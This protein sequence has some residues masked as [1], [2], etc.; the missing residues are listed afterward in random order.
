M[1]SSVIVLEPAE[2]FDLLTLQEAK[3]NLGLAS[4]DTSLDE[5]LEFLI[6]RAS[7]EMATLCDRVFA[8]ER[9]L[10]IFYD[11]GTAQRLYLS[12]YPVKPSDIE[13]ISENGTLL[14]T[15]DV[16]EESGRITK[17]TGAFAGPVAVTYRGGYE[18]PFEAP[19]ALRQA[20]LLSTTTAYYAGVRGDSS[21][22][23]LSHKESRITYF[24]PSTQPSGGGGGGGMVTGSRAISD[25][26]VH[27]MRIQI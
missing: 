23:S 18:L 25:L 8:K 24:N 3:V 27:F 20:A 2:I 19:L 9:V 26:L 22:S 17:W 11:V 6:A 21:V 12:R 7:G 14:T 15:Y 4:T 10:E 1:I 16:H 13:S 5:K